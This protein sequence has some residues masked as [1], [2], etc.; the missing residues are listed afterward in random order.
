MI[1]SKIAE[2]DIAMSYISL[3]QAELNLCEIN[4]KSFENVQKEGEQAREKYLSKI[5]LDDLTDY[6]VMR[7]FYS[8]MYRTA[9]FPNIA[10]EYDKHGNAIHYSPYTGDAVR[11]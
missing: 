7:T 3:E 2:L 5:Q 11:A 4:G 8:C 10:Y 6:D 9:T 1:N